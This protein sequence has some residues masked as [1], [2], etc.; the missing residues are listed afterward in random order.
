MPMTNTPASIVTFSGQKKLSSRTTAGKSVGETGKAH[1]QEIPYKICVS[2]RLVRK[3][4][5]EL[6][7]EKIG[8]KS[9]KKG[10]LSRRWRDGNP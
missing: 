3:A 1:A 5:F 2:Y 8:Y 10:D 7:Q 4:W 9:K 6:A